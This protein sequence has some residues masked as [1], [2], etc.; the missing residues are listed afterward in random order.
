MDLTAVAMAQEGKLP[1]LVF[2]QGKIGALKD[3]V[4]GEGVSTLMSEEGE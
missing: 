2:N 1:V 4:C 3:A